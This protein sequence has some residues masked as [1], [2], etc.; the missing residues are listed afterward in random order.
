M[1]VLTYRHECKHLVNYAD[2]LYLIERLRACLKQD[3]HAKQDGSYHIRS[4]YFDSLYDKALFEKLAGVPVRDKYRIRYYHFDPSF[5]RLEKKEKRYSAG[6]KRSMP[7]DAKEAA[8][9]LQ[10][11][12]E[13]LKTSSQALAREFYLALHTQILIPKTIVQ[14][15]RYA[16]IYPVA[17]VR[18]T[19]DTDLRAS[20]DVRHFL[21]RRVPMAPMLEK[22]GSIVEVKWDEFCPEFI[23]DLVQMENRQTAAASK[24]ALCR[25]FW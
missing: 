4:L 23:L 25:Q 10:G 14:Y 24:Y 11:D 21:D 16:F 17:N 7:L 20:A 18:V 13:F 8:R 22:G 6:A 3:A 1:P 2:S 12:D 9:I 5:L 19:V 15:R